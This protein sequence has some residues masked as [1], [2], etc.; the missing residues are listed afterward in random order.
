MTR[1]SLFTASPLAEAMRPTRL[2][3]VVGQVELTA[4]LSRRMNAAGSF[5]LWGPPGTGKTTI[6]RI[7]G[8]E[9]GQRFRP[10][11]A[12]FD[13]VAEL[14]RIFAEA[15]PL[16]E[17]GQATL[18]FV[19][20]I[21]RFNKAQQD[22]LLPAVEEGMIRLIGATTE[23][24]SFSLNSALLSRVQV[25]VLNAL[26]AKALDQLIGRAEAHI[27]KPLPLEEGA[28]QALIGMA[29]GDGRYLINLMETILEL[30]Q[31]GQPPL[32][33][34]GLGQLLSKRALNY[35][36]AGDEHYNLISAL[37]KSLRASDCDA[38]LYWLARMMLAG[39][40]P[41]YILRRLTRFA[42]EDIGLAAPEA[43]GKAISAWQSYERLGSPEGDLAIAELVIFLATSPKSNAAY[44]AWKQAMKT[45]KEAGHHNPP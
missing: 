36:R 21:H 12:V 29:D 31:D 42:L 25:L 26:D 6:A 28:R 27:G 2:Q 30:C 19:D 23:N 39:E 1:A 11:S 34:E 38:G 41:Y 43:V 9:A 37:H 14:R 32:D 16:F 44:S 20:E 13:G 45:A 17:A 40:D 18:L 15:R 22:A 35:D 7:M 24:P 5:I 10:I 3:D 4:Q 33:A 8:E